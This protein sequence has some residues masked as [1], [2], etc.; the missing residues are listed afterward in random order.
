MSEKEILKINQQL[1]SAK[2]QGLFKQNDTSLQ[3]KGKL[4]GM[5]VFSWVYP[6]IEVLNLTL[7]AFPFP[8]LWLGN[9]AEI[10]A[11]KSLNSEWEIN[12]LSCL[13]YNEDSDLE[14]QLQNQL[15]QIKEK[16]FKPGILLFT[17]SDGNTENAVRQFNEFLNLVQLK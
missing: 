5:D 15:A 17:S 11:L 12:I 2:E 4:F 1:K 6:N 13:V 14:N 10:S 3:P 8:V 7:S 16:S 9:E